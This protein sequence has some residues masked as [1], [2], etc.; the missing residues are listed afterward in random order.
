MNQDYRLLSNFRL[1]ELLSVLLII[2]LLNAL[3]L[4][5]Y[6]G[7]VV[8][9]YAVNQAYMMVDVRTNLSID[10]A[11]TGN[12]NGAKDYTYLAEDEYRH[13]EHIDVN[14]QGHISVKSRLIDDYNRI[15]GFVKNALDG[16]TLVWHKNIN[17]QNGYE[18]LSWR[19][20]NSS[21][22]PPFRVIDP[23]PKATLETKY[24]YFFC[25]G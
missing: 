1:V 4:P 17:T 12:A 9:A 3:C 20:K 2:V 5:I 16:K 15:P 7:Y 22:E 25:G 19:C 8:N 21:N 6:K 10:S 11:Y 24:D 18:F 14:H 13:V 23:A